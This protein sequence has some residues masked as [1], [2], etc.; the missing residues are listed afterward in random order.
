MASKSRIVLFDSTSAQKKSYGWSDF[1][2]RW[3]DFDLKRRNI[4]KRKKHF[5]LIRKWQQQLLFVMA[6]DPSHL[7]KFTIGTSKLFTPADSI[8]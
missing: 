4:G 5:Q 7:P 8:S 2:T 6:R 1:R 3:M